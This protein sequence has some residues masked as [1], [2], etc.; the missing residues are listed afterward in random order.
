[1]ANS[2]AAQLHAI[3]RSCQRSRVQTS[4]RSPVIGRSGCCW[5]DAGSGKR[6]PWRNGCVG[7]RPLRPGPARPAP[8]AAPRALE[9]F[10]IG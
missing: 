2:Y 6:E 7:K 10:P 8:A 4:C 9:R 1:M 5:P 3:E